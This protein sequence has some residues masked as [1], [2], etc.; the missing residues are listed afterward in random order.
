MMTL[1]KTFIGLIQGGACTQGLVAMK[2]SPPN[3][4]NTRV[5]NQIPPLWA[6]K[7]MVKAKTESKTHEPGSPGEFVSSKQKDIDAG[8]TSKRDL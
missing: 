8:F 4:P 7:A 1:V 3:S 6:P 2:I 5:F